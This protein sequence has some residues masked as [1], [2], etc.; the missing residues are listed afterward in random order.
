MCS[1]QSLY[2]F[3]NLSITLVAR[4]KWTESDYRASETD[5]RVV[6]VIQTS[7]TLDRAV[8]LRVRPLTYLQAMEI[9]DV[10]IPV[11]LPT[12]ARCMHLFIP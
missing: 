9:D 1:R 2:T 10:D 12:A 7:A 4:I 5:L 8:S 11:N 3:A 6:G